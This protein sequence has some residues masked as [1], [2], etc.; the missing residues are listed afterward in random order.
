MRSPQAKPSAMITDI[1]GTM[2]KV[3]IEGAEQKSEGKGEK[4]IGSVALREQ[5]AG[6]E[7]RE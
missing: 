2:E 4:K 1:T 6:V 7:G 5:G 3:T